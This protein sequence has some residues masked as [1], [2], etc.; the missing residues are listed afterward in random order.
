[1]ALGVAAQSGISLEDAKRQLRG[2]KPEFSKNGSVRGQV[3]YGM[4]RDALRDFAEQND[5]TWSIQDGKITFIPLTSF[6]P[7]EVPLISQDTG[8]LGIPE[9]TQGGIKARV[10]LNP[11]LK[12]GQRI[13]LEA[14]LNPFRYPLGSG[15]Q[16]DNIALSISSTK[17]NADG[18]YYVMRAEHVG[19]TR[20]DEWYT[21]LTCLAVDAT[22]PLD[23]APKAAVQTEAASIRRD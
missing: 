20:G 23:Y 3:F 14:T 15:V 17:T 22:V 10:L 5:C 9:V 19:D 6:I 12:I 8:L 1:M 2:Y 21:D 18:L 16:R 11:K 13:K 7:G 4:A